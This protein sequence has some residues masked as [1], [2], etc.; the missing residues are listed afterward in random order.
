M[1]ICF[2]KKS[3]LPLALS[4]LYLIDYLTEENSDLKVYRWPV[5]RPDSDSDMTRARSWLGKWIHSIEWQK[6]LRIFLG[7]FS[8]CSCCR[9]LS[10]GEATIEVNTVDGFQVS[11]ELLVYCDNG[12]TFAIIQ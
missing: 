12:A 11:F 2:E 1:C 5:T 9:G 10:R 8:K 3:H 7:L 6:H 4:D